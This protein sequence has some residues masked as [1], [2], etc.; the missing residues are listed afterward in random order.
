VT[1]LGSPGAVQATGFG[2]ASS[3]I[4][5]GFGLGPRINAGGRVGKSDLGVRLLTTTDPAEAEALAAELDRPNEERRALELACIAEATAAAEA[6]SDA[7]L[8]PVAGTGR[9][10]GVIG[11]APRRREEQGDPGDDVAGAER[12]VPGAHRRRR[13]Y[14]A[15]GRGPQVRLDEL[16]HAGIL[17]QSERAEQTGKLIAKADMPKLDDGRDCG[18][19]NNKKSADSGGRA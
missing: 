8:I 19:C 3:G 1:G 7:P 18:R 17:E 15:R 10:P 11:T 14:D 16:E 13:P 6:Q 9:P 5:V 2:F 4:S 12:V